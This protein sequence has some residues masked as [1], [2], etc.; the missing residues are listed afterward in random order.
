MYHFLLQRYIGIGGVCKG[1]K[2]EKRKKTELFLLH[3]RI[4]K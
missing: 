4:N 1:V 3:L 2:K